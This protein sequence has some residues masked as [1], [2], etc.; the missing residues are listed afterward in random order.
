MT[1][2]TLCRQCTCVYGG[3][4]KAFLPPGRR[5]SREAAVPQD[6]SGIIAKIQ[7]LPIT[8]AC[9]VPNSR[10]VSAKQTRPAS[11]LTRVYCCTFIR[12]V[13]WH[14]M[15]IHH[16]FQ[17]DEAG[18]TFFPCTGRQLSWE[19]PKPDAENVLVHDLHWNRSTHTRA[20][21]SPLPELLWIQDLQS[22]GTHG[23]WLVNDFFTW[24]VLHPGL[25]TLEKASGSLRAR[26]NF[27][28]YG[29]GCAGVR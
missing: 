3:L 26:C 7:K 8:L 19:V 15:H 11:L 5:G 25:G 10:Q 4:L 18:N 29:A 24:E 14:W 21:C 20:T 9:S 2:H 28:G 6:V 27:L 16:L 1:R 17:Y 23:L 12:C 13:Q 22:K